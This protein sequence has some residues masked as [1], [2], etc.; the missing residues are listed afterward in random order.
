MEDIPTLTKQPS[1]TKQGSF[2]K[3]MLVKQP[4]LTRPTAPTLY[5]PPSTNNQS[6]PPTGNLLLTNSLVSPKNN[7]EKR[8]SVISTLSKSSS[9]SSRNLQRS[10]Q[11]FSSFRS[12]LKELI[13]LRM[14]QPHNLLM[15]RVLVQILLQS[16][17]IIEQQAVG[18]ILHM[19][20]TVSD[21][22]L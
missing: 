8:Y 10:E 5:S 1:L 15:V 9:S 7:D 22:I 17:L 18:M 12:R 21:N 2:T 20:L 19:N 4:S 16:V 13:C 6:L 14:V 11:M 3:P